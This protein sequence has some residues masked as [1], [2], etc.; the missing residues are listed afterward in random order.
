MKRFEKT[1]LTPRLVYWYGT[2]WNDLSNSFSFLNPK[3]IISY[4]QGIQQGSDQLSSAIQKKMA[5]GKQLTAKESA[6]VK[7][8][9][10]LKE[11]SELPKK[12]RLSWLNI[13][14][15]EG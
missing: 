3:A 14:E 15:E 9:V 6:L 1:N 10:E 13:E 12:A 11:E 8:L 5:A 4:E 7:G 2:T